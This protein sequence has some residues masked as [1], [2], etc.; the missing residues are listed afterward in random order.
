[1]LDFR[2]LLPYGFDCGYGTVQ[3]AVLQ[4][5]VHVIKLSCM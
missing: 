3:V 2:G 4:V 5:Q 1:L